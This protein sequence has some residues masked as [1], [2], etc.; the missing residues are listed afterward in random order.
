M[1]SVKVNL[2]SID[3]VKEFVNIMSHKAFDAD[4]IS[5]RYVINAKSIMGIFSFNLT[6]PKELR[7]YVTTE[8]E[9][10]AFKKEL[11]I[12]TSFVNPNTQGR[13]RDI[14]TSGK[15]NI[16][17]L[18]S[19]YVKLDHIEDAFKPGPRNGKFIVIP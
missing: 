5:D 10:E 3:R 14:I 8:D 6:E 2:N 13:A 1:F 4:L 16:V 9:F 7:A 19:D 18:I 12:K 15:L 11:T 17:D